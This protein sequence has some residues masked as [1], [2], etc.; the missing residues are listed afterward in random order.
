MSGKHWL[1]A[2]VVVLAGA[3]I[4]T[5]VVAA[6]APPS[7][8]LSN[9]GCHRAML[10]SARKLAI[11]AVMRPV[12]GTTSM[13]MMFD[14]QRAKR[15]AGPF[16]SRAWARARPMGPS[17]ESHA[18]AAAGRH[19]EGRAEG[20][21]PVRARRTTGSGS[22]SAGSGSSARTLGTA[23]DLSPVCYQPELRPDLIG[24]LA[25]R[26]PRDGPADRRTAM[27]PGSATAA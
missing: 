21:Q 12:S 16:S 18:R 6:S 3:C 24:A 1:L 15:R 17:R 4:W 7:T 26:D 20:E 11:T 25:D 23:D 14:L 8:Q 22:A 27:W 5:P 9:P 2:G 10:P 19:L 13:E